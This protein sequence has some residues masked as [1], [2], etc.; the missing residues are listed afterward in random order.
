[1]FQDVN[2]HAESESSES[3]WTALWNHSPLQEPPFWPAPPA[4]MPLTYSVPEVASMLRI[5]RNTAYELVARGEI[6]SIRLGRRVLIIR[7]AFERWL[8]APNH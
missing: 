6:P 7:A 1:V 2:A 4:L 3:R 8:A 5:N